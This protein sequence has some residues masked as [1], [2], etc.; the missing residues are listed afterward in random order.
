MQV[1]SNRAGGSSPSKQVGDLAD[2]RTAGSAVNSPVTVIRA[3]SG[4]VRSTRTSGASGAAGAGGGSPGL[5]TGGPYP[6]T[7][8]V[9]PRGVDG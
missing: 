7:A 6:A 8:Q 5:V 1:S 4:P 9:T 2:D 3:A